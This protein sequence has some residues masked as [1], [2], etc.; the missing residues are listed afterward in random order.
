M[1]RYYASPLGGVLLCESTGWRA[2]M[3]VHWVACYYAS[4]LGG[5]LLCESTGWHA[6]MRVHWVACYYASP[7]GG[8]LLCVYPLSVHTTPSLAES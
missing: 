5:V 7:L 2:T 1:A 6:T 4:P 8:V 3:R